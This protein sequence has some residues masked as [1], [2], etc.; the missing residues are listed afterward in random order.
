[1]TDLFLF[2]LLLVAIAIGWLLGR[3]QRDSAKPAAAAQAARRQ[4]DERQ[5]AA[6][7]LVQDLPDHALDAFLAAL[8]VNSD[9]LETHLALGA[10]WRKKGEIERSIRIHEHLLRRTG[11]KAL[12]KE[13]VQY[14]LA[15]DFVR[16]GLLD[17]A[18]RELQQLVEHSRGYRQSALFQLLDLYQ[19]S[20]EWRKAINV[21]NLIVD[22]AG[23]PPLREKMNRLRGHYYCELADEAL[24]ETDYLGV[25]RA[26]G[27]AMQYGPD[28]E[29]PQ[30]LLAE[31]EVA[32][33]HC[34]DAVRLLDQ[35]VQERTWLPPVL[36]EFLPAHHEKLCASSSAS[37]YQLLLLRLYRQFG[38]HWIAELLLDL[39]H[40]Q[41]GAETVHAFIQQEIR[42]RPRPGLIGEAIARSIF[43]PADQ[44]V[45]SAVIKLLQ[46]RQPINQ[47]FVCSDCGFSAGQWHWQ[48]PGCKHW[49]SLALS[50]SSDINRGFNA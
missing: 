34:E 14:E 15:V 43:T 25:R 27:R 8:D 7:V 1:M 2:V 28:L 21:A 46:T 31:L 4:P 38:E 12:Q 44:Q 20:H 18:E 42:D 3:F 36:R 35:L 11:L 16:A 5:I 19:Q 23:T 24:R 26:L 37:D 50:S 49:D 41:S 13:L 17:R 29:R 6:S 39:M 10:A 33:G 40:Q 48:C 47:K 32:V 22:S 45:R 30:V 9:T